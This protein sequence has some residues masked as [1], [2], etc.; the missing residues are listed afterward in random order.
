MTPRTSAAFDLD[1][2][3]RFRPG[4]GPAVTGRRPALVSQADVDWQPPADPQ[5]DLEDLEGSFEQLKL[6][7]DRD[8]ETLWCAF[9]HPERPCFTRPLLRDI[10][11]FQRRLAREARRAPA[12]GRSPF[13][14]LVWHSTFPHVWNLGGDLELF[15]GLIRARERET[16]RSYAHACVETVH[17]NLTKLDAPYLTIALIQGDTLGGGF[18]AA[19]TN[20]VIVAERQSKFG[21]PETLF[22][23]FPGMGAYSLLSRRLDGVRADAMIRSGRLYSADDLL[24]MGLIDL[25]VEPGAGEAA[26]EAW[27]ERNRRRHRVLLSMSEV[28]RRCQPLT[29]DE[30]TEVTDL[31]VETALG[32][33]EA[34]LRKMERLARAQHRRRTREVSVAA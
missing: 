21:L 2:D 11:S 32:L 7:L 16:L 29:M 24:D 34:D 27:I 12:D 20:D 33:E 15:V 25:V 19:L 1:P 10:S 26:V 3:R 13:R 14:T 28:R 4:V 5:P 31:W 30:L 6:R 9:A 8:R 22:N 17:Q 18:E 23:M